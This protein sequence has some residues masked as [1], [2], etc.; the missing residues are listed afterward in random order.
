MFVQIQIPLILRGYTNNLELVSLE[1][2]T[3]GEC[4]A[5]LVRRYPD[6]GAAIFNSDGTRS[7]LS[8]LCNIKDF[9]RLLGANENVEDGDILIILS[10]GG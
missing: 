1:G 5:D 7:D 3:V 8:P 6:I 4:L 9:H 10:P 2:N